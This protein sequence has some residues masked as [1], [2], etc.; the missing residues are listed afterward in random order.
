M[1]RALMIPKAQLIEQRDTALQ[2]VRDT[3]AHATKAG[4]GCPECEALIGRYDALLAQ[5]DKWEKP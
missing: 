2:L 4:R 5:R 3:I 1:P